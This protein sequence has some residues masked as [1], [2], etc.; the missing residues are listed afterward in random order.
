LRDCGGLEPDCERSRSD[1]ERIGIS[2]FPLSALPNFLGLFIPVFARLAVS[3]EREPALAVVVGLLTHAPGV[4][5]E[6]AGDDPVSAAL[7]AIARDT[8]FESAASDLAAQLGDPEARSRLGGA[9]LAS[10]GPA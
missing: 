9:L 2:P 3:R 7:L 8:E 10:L 5:G 1:F 6:R 4:G